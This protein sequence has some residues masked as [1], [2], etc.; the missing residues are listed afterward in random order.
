LHKGFLRIVKEAIK[1]A[2]LGVAFVIASAFF[3]L[4]PRTGQTRIAPPLTMQVTQTDVAALVL[5]IEDEIYDE[6]CQ[7]YVH[8]IASTGKGNSYRLPVY[9]QPALNDQRLGWAI[10]K[11]RPM[12][13]VLREFS[14]DHGLSYLYG[15]P[16]WDFPP[17]EP[18]YLTVYMDDDQLCQFKHEW[19]RTSFT[20][21]L[22]PTEQRVREAAQRQQSRLGKDYRPHK[23]DCSFSWR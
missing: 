3:L 9:V 6:G 10:Y 4:S 7:G 22:P 1:M 11:L 14:V 17:T 2:K 23:R 12:G 19:I 20:I 18:S 15:H 21:E 13:E 8:D 16:E 5:A